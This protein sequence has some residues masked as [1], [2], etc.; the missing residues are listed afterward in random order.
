VFPTTPDLCDVIVDT[1]DLPYP[2]YGDPD[3]DLYTAFQTRFSAGAPLPAW[4]VA[5]G[6]GEIRFLWRATGG[7]LFGHYP[8]GDEILDQIREIVAE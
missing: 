7:G 8:E 6:T 3:R 4:I 2:I 1:L 5:D